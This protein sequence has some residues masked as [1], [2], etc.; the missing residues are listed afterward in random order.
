MAF[1]QRDWNRFLFVTCTI[2][3]KELKGAKLLLFLISVQPHRR[4]DLAILKILVDNGVD[5]S[6]LMIYIY[7]EIRHQW[8][9]YLSVWVSQTFLQATIR[10]TAYDIN[11]LPL[12]TYSF[13]SLLT[14]KEWIYVFG[15]TAFFHSVTLLVLCWIYL[16]SLVDCKLLGA[17]TDFLLRVCIVPG[18]L[19]SYCDHILAATQCK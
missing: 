14:E 15:H 9:H 6:I 18:T 19:G 17:W 7:S 4:K 5:A 11:F 10:N 3:E 2:K 8:P 13:L 1:D 16:F 12:L